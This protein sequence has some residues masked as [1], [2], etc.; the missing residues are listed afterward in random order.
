MREVY[1]NVK[2]PLV[3]DLPYNIT[4]LEG[5]GWVTRKG[6]CPA[7]TGQPVIIPGSMGAYSYLMVGKGNSAFCNSASH[8]AGRIRSRFDLSRR[9][10]S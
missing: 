2:A 4:L 10:A 6:G 3:Y 9:G 1:K 8:G 7:N 5:E